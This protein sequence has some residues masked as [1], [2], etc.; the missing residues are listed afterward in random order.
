MRAMGDTGA[1]MAAMQQEHCCTF[2]D[3]VAR[4]RLQHWQHEAAR[5]SCAYESGDS[6]VVNG[7]RHRRFCRRPFLAA[8]RNSGYSIPDSAFLDCKACTLASRLIA[9]QQIEADTRAWRKEVGRLSCKHE[10]RGP[11]GGFCM[12]SA[13][14]PPNVGSDAIAAKLAPLFAG[15]SVLDVGCGMG[16]YGAYFRQ[17]EP[18]VRWTGVDGSEGIEEASGG[19]VQFADLAVDGLPRSLRRQWDW[20]F[21]SQV[22]EHVPPGDEAA[23]M[24]TL[25]VHATRGVVLTWASLGQAGLMHVNNQSPEY[26]SCMMG[27]LGF[28]GD[29][30][31][32]QGLPAGSVFRRRRD[33]VDLPNRASSGFVDSYRQARRRCGFTTWGYLKSKPRAIRQLAARRAVLGLP[34]KRRACDV[35]ARDALDSLP[36]TH[37]QQ[38]I[39]LFEAL[40]TDEVKPAHRQELRELAAQRYGDSS[41]AHVGQA[42]RAPMW[43]TNASMATW[44]RWLNNTIWGSCIQPSEGFCFYSRNPVRGHPSP[45]VMCGH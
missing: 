11:N 2:E 20:T 24:H 8:S 10:Q 28:E 30:Q 18:S 5:L 42:L 37:S 4:A 33:A 14:P 21:S 35:S 23:F 22:A 13:K 41:R 15:A 45:A 25:V 44:H 6:I 26:V 40:V 36:A 27:Y 19:L 38:E 34:M 31:A 12:D 32:G 9:L 3:V 43:A 1:A 7:T 29:A 16:S 39:E 17:H